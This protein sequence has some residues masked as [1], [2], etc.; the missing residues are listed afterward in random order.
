MGKYKL[1]K[2]KEISKKGNKEMNDEQMV[3]KL[4][5]M[6]S[7]QSSQEMRSNLEQS[8]MDAAARI[9]TRTSTPSNGDLL[10]LYGL[11]KQVTEGDC[12][13]AQ[14]WAVQV[15]ARAKWEAWNKNKKMDKF[16]AMRNYIDKV[17]ELMCLLV[18]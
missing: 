7:A 1:C 16:T 6:G 8:F 14:P 4:Q 2:K 13:T 3:G 10:I 11:Y 17:E 12:E 15:Q 5:G 18:S 9:K